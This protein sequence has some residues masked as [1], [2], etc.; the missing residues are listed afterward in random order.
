M[1]FLT[2]YTL[3]MAEFPKQESFLSLFGINTDGEDGKK[4]KRAFLPRMDSSET[5]THYRI[6]IEVPGIVV[7]DIKIEVEHRVLYIS[8]EKKHQ[9]EEKDQKHHRQECLYGEFKQELAL[10]DDALT[11]GIQATCKEHV[12]VILIPKKP[13]DRKVI[14]VQTS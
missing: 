10:P 14:P 6:T 7:K 13:S 4:I 2:L 12:L 11:D 1:F 9:T 8:G 3:C 5:K